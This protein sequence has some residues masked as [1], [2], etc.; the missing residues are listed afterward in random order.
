M[1]YPNSTHQRSCPLPSILTWLLLPVIYLLLKWTTTGLHVFGESSQVFGD[2]CPASPS[3]LSKLVK[4]QCCAGM[5]HRGRQ[6]SRVGSIE[7]ALPQKNFSLL[8]KVTG[9]NHVF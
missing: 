9:P 5:E 4:R 6:D 1:F 2:L 8:G 3:S 7:L